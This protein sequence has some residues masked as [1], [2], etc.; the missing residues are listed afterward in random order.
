[1]VL[2]TSLAFL[3]VF[4]LNRVSIRFWES[5]TMWGNVTHNTR[6]LVAGILV[7]CRHSPTYRDN[8][9]RWAASFCVAAKHFIR[10]EHDIPP[11]ELAG[12]LSKSDISKMEDANHAPLY[13][14]SMVRYYLRQALLPDGNKKGSG[15]NV[16]PMPPHLYYANAVQMTHLEELINSMIAQVSGME[17]VRSTPLPVVYVTH[18]RTFLFTYL[19]VLPYVWVDSW[20]WA[21]I[22]LVTFA[23]FALLGIEGASSECEIPFDKNRPNHLAIDAYCMII[24]DSVQGLVVHDANLDMI[25]RQNHDDSDM[26]NDNSSNSRSYYKQGSFIED[27]YGEESER[28]ITEHA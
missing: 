18:L 2:K 5:R 13:A 6:N 16:T 9:I 1:M 25:E 22:P 20:S 23:A 3:L 4:R 17:R 7:H 8:A 14:A 10:N 26:F 24:L 21:T 27:Y 19:M 11:D 12:V 28:N 15:S